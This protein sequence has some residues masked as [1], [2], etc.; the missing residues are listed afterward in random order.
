MAKRRN[1]G[2]WSATSLGYREHVEG[3]LETLT[4]YWPLTLQQVYYQLVAQGFVEN[5]KPEYQKLSRVLT[6]ARFDGLVSWEAL[7]D[8]T[9]SLHDSSEWLDSH[10]FVRY[11][12]SEFLRGYRRDL[13]QSQDVGLEIWIEKDALSRICHDAAF[14]Y[15]VPVVVARG[16]NS[17]SYVH[18][19][20]KR[21]ERNASAGKKTRILYFGDLDPSGWEMLPAMLETLQVEMGLGETVEGIR[22]ALTPEQVS[23][24]DLPR[25]V[26]ALK[27]SDPRSRKYRE[28]FG[29]LAVE[30]DAVP[31]AVL[32]EMVEAA[33]EQ[34]ID[35]ELLDG[36]RAK[37][38]R[39][40]ETLSSLRSRV[41]AVIGSAMVEGN[42]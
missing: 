5:R 6:K 8:R 38:Q 2:G 32:S 16:F 7:E 30:L 28:R 41:N 17:V 9:R 18:E 33:I 27:A 19:C 23:D 42:R 1:R 25:S 10:S 20:R 39:E 13:L 3:V 29:D 22:C 4:E 15:C 34:Q 35:S 12:I 26:D 31:P 36:E 11:E 14:P 40:R 21:V 37:E 24:L